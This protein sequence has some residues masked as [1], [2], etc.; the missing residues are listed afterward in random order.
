VAERG[1]EVL[2]DELRQRGLLTGGAGEQQVVE[3]LHVLLSHAPSR[4]LGVSVADLVGD[5]RTQNQPGTHREYP[6][7]RV[8]LS[9]ADGRPLL[10]EDLADHPRA[11]A[12]AA[13]LDRGVTGTRKDQGLG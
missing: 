6:N 11:R 13:V 12:L 7:W 2:L 9:G 3:A 10:L 4:L 5:R 1:R 8:P